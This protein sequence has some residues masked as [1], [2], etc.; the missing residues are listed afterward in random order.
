MRI[1]LSFLILFVLSNCSGRAKYYSICERQAYISS[2]L[3]HSSLAA[4]NDSSEMLFT[5][6]KGNKRNLYKMRIKHGRYVI[7]DSN[8]QYSPTGFSNQQHVCLHVAQLRQKLDS[9][10]IREYEGERDSLGYLLVLYMQDNG[11]VFHTK[12]TLGITHLETLKEIRKSKLICEGWYSA[13][14]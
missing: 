12:D 2:L 13:P 6:T 4:K 10:G 14:E 11:V 3:E 8:V 5:T 7:L 1:T 9:F